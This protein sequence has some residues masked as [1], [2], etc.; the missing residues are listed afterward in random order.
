[1]SPRYNKFL[2]DRCRRTCRGT[3]KFLSKSTKSITYTYTTNPVDLARA[4]PSFSVLFLFIHERG[5]FL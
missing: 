5:V 1:M 4:S 2:S 3:F